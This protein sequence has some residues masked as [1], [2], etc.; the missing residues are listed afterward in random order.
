METVQN[1]KLKKHFS[2][3]EIINNA[4]LLAIAVNPKEY[5]EKYRK[6]YR[7]LNKKHKGLRKD[8]AALFFEAHAQRI[9]SINELKR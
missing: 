5:F 7:E 9:M 1:P 6:I 2:L 4:T 8:T 3:Y